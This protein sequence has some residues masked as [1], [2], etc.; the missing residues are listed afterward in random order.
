MDT[1][2]KQ[3]DESINSETLKLKGKAMKYGVVSTLQQTHKSIKHFCD[4]ATFI[5]VNG[6]NISSTFSI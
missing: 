2:W 6:Q 1:D 4:I 3:S 5:E